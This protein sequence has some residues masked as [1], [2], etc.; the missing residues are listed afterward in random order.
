MKQMKYYVESYGCTLNQGETEMIA[1]TY[2]KRGHERVSD[3]SDADLAI[4][5]TCVVIK[6]TEER[7]KRRI[8]ELKDEC[9]DLIVTGCLTTTDKEE[10][11]KKCSEAELIKPGSMNMTESHNNSTTGVIPISTGCVGN[12]SYCIT[13]L[14]RG[15]LE[16]R[17]LENIKTRFKSLLNNS[18]NEIRLSCQD[19][20]SY[21]M[22]IETDLPELLNELTS[23]EGDYRIRVGMMNPDTVEPIESEVIESMKD[24][25]IYNFLHLPLQSGSGEILEKMNRRYKVSDWRSIV[26]DFRD[27]LPALSLSTDVIVGF[28]GEN[29]DDFDRTLDVLKETKPDIVNVTRFSPRPGTEAYE[30][31]DK[32]KSLEKKNRSKKLT[33][34]RFQISRENNEEFLGKEEDVLVLE[35]GKGDSLKGRMDNYKVVVLKGESKDLIGRRVKVKITDHA[36]V[37][38]VGE[39]IE[40]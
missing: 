9:S 14:A 3:P 20:A 2:D 30:M 28:P 39:R 13:K 38:L 34:L 15:N 12:C 37:Y 21:G 4:I 11:R 10:I 40:S 35:E 32:V 5:G 31:A 6:K 22:D 27:E 24:E 18:V 23:V 25:H 1:D 29:K 8:D 16:S 26:K 17:S 36:D 19:T 7:M 33:D